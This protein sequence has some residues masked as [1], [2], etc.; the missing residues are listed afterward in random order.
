MSALVAAAR[1]FPAAVAELLVDTSDAL[2]DMSTA[3]KTL[4]GSTGVLVLAFVVFG[5]F[6]WVRV[7]QVIPYSSSCATTLVQISQQTAMVRPFFIGSFVLSVVAF[8]FTRRGLPRGLRFAY[9]ITLGIGAALL[10]APWIV[11]LAYP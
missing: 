9:L 2:D 3:Q 10:V 5:V 8:G 7:L 6:T 4:V 1:A 11:D